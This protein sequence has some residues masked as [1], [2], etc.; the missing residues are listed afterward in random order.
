MSCFLAHGRQSSHHPSTHD[1]E[2]S[3]SLAI[4]VVVFFLGGGGGGG[5]GGGEERKG[6]AT[7]VL[8]RPQGH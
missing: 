8:D 3:I 7:P 4:W 6:E 1:H 2:Y 5:G